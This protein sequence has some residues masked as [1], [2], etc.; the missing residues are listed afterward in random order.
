MKYKRT[1]NLE[2]GDITIIDANI[3][4]DSKAL[5]FFIKE[6]NKGLSLIGKTP[7]LESKIKFM[8]YE[9]ELLLTI[10][11]RMNKN[12]SLIY[13]M[14][15]RT[16]LPVSKLIL[17][18]F[19][20]QQKLYFVLVNEDNEM[21]TQFTTENRFKKILLNRNKKQ[22]KYS[23]YISEYNKSDKFEWETPAEMFKSM[24]FV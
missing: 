9:D 19:I 23:P 22:F 14:Y 17:D 18:R 15:V 3:N 4:N 2:V 21:I 13:G 8:K 20:F 16:D 11:F 24:Y 1:K 6:N 5:T 10:M 12:D 7:K